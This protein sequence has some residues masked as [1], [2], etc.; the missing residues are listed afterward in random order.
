MTC[1]GDFEA[2]AVTAA[3]AFAAVPVTLGAGTRTVTGVLGIAGA[4]GA[5]VGGTDAARCRMPGTAGV[6]TLGAEG[7]GGAEE[8][9]AATGEEACATGP[10]APEPL[11]GRGAAEGLLGVVGGVRPGA[12]CLPAWTAEFVCSPAPSGPAANEG[13]TQTASSAHN[14]TT[15]HPARTQPPK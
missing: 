8:G 15:A 2:G 10:D 3:T 6:P 9:V 4:A 11:A 1:A 13:V 5:E 14:A 12:A 7:L